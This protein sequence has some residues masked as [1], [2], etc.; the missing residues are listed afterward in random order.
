MLS[1]LYNIFAL[2]VLHN[3]GQLFLITMELK[4]E[5]DILW[6]CYGTL[7]IASSSLIY[8]TFDSKAQDVMERLYSALL[9]GYSADIRPSITHTKPINVSVYFSLTQI[10]DMDERHQILTTSAWTRYEWN[11]FR[12]VWDP[13]MYDNVTRIH[14]PAA[15]VWRPD[16][17]LLDNADEQYGKSITQTD[18]VV[19]YLGNINWA[20]ACL[21]TSSCPLDIKFYPFDRQTCVLK[22]GSWAYDGSKIDIQLGSETGDMSNYVMNTEWNVLRINAEKNPIIYSCCPN[23]PYPIVDILITIERRPMFYVFNLIIPC[24]LIS[25]IA[26]LSFY[27][28]SNEGEKVT[29]GTY[30]G[31]TIVIVALS[32]AMSVFTLNIHHSGDHGEQVP[33]FLQIFAFKIL[34]K[35]LFIE[36]VPYHSINRHVKFMY[37]KEHPNEKENLNLYLKQLECNEVVPSDPADSPPPGSESVRPVVSSLSLQVDSPSRKSKKKVSFS[38]PALSFRSSLPSTS[39]GSQRSSVAAQ[40]DDGTNNSGGVDPFEAE[41]L[42]VMATIN[43][44][45]ERNELRVAEMDKRDARRLEW[46]QVAMVLDRFLLI[47]FFMGTITYTVVILYQKELGIFE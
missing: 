3:I 32:T 46:E 34:S 14:F 26:L 47:V 42:R 22:Y 29:L 16:V 43:G 35:V 40:N 30:Y 21:F 5:T 2:L 36:L 9:K 28:P 6:F 41:F 18:V 1:L 25:L 44:M 39:P 15:V 27:M 23:D 7:K 31:I 17:I 45:I 10:I 24:V 11:D 33:P 38:S 8:Q 4:A 19:D 12:L 13:R 20:T 37:E